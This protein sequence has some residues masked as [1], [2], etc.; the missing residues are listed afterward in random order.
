MCEYI[1]CLGAGW[2]QV[3]T[4]KALVLNGYKVLAVDVDKKA[5]GLEICEKYIAVDIKDSYTIS[6]S[7]LDAGYKIRCVIAPINDV[8]QKSGFEIA[9]FFSIPGPCVS[10]SIYSNS[11]VAIKLKLSEFYLSSSYIILNSFT[12]YEEH[13]SFFK[14][15]D[16]YICKPSASAGS[17]GIQIYNGEDINREQFENAK[18][19]ALFFSNDGFAIFEK[20]I[21]GDEYSI[22]SF[23]SF[24]GV[25]QTLVIS[26][27]ILEGVSATRIQSIPYDSVAYQKLSEFSKKI[28]TKLEYSLGP[29]HIEV[30][31]S[32]SGDIFP[33][34][35]GLRGGG[36]WVADRM[37]AR[38]VGENLG[39]LQVRAML[40]KEFV[41]ENLNKSKKLLLY[42]A[43]DRAEIKKQGFQLIDRI[44]FKKNNDLNLIGTDSD[45]ASSEYWEMI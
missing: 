10:A 33:I 24:K 14:S 6:K 45:R 38:T 32:K 3:E 4:I 2:Q 27:R 40:C 11:K 22:E 30:R 29:S 21:D 12:E 1:L 41:I 31:I 36:F 13:L 7:I 15:D 37:V 42:D 8:G 34:D 26:R 18:K 28:L 44:E 16:K 5:P 17:R 20:Y 43:D 35:I 19:K 9:Q 39:L 25:H 23:T